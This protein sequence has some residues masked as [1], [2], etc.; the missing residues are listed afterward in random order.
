[1]KTLLLVDGS[2]YLYRAF[3]AMPDLRNRQ[4]EPTGAIQ[5][6]VEARCRGR[7]IDEP[8]GDAGFGYDPLFLIPEY[9]RTFAELGEIVKHQLSHRSR[10]FQH[11]RPLLRRLCAEGKL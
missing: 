6:E 7:I 4:N 11:L 5:G 1:M 9:H 8:R 10:A 2:S 3:H